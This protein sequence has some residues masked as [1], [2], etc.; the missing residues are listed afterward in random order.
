[1]KEETLYHHNIYFQY[2]YIYIYNYVQLICTCS[3]NALFS[4]NN[5]SNNNNSCIKP[6]SNISLFDTPLG[7]I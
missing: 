4:C 2:T 1:M 6:Q 3:G 5:S 7:F